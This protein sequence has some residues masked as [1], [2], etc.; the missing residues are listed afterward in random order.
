MRSIFVFSTSFIFSQTINYNLKKGFIDYGFDV[1]SYFNNE[2]K[3]GSK[4]FTATHN[5]VK[6]KFSSK[7]NLMHFYENPN[8]YIPQYGGYCAYAVALKGDK[9]PINP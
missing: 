2:V 9:A 3:E 1:V 8:K 5:G 6:F 4:Q 7:E